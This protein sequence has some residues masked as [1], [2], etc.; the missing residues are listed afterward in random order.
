MSGTAVDLLGLARSPLAA[1]NHSMSRG[2][3][4]VFDRISE[5]LTAK[6]SYAAATALRGVADRAISNLLTD[7][8]TQMAVR[9]A[10][11]AG[12]PALPLRQ[13][14]ALAI[15]ASMPRIVRYPASSADAGPAT[16]RIAC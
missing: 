2:K 8:R 5:Q 1:D 16:E 15:V 6:A 12:V 3:I 9:R 14:R 13:E 11:R 10:E 7:V 4:A